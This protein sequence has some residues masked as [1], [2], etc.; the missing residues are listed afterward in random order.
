MVTVGDLPL[1]VCP[2]RPKRVYSERGG[3]R[4]RHPRLGHRT[5]GNIHHYEIVRPFL[6]TPS[7]VLF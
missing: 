5:G 3:S 4:T 7:G 6:C 1:V 2:T